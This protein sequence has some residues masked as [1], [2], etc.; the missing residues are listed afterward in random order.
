MRELDGQAKRI[1]ATKAN[2]EFL[3]EIA[4][5]I[6]RMQEFESE[7]DL[8]LSKFPGAEEVLHAVTAK[9]SEYVDRERRLV[10]NPQAAVARGQLDVEANQA[11]ITTSQFRNSAQSLIASL[12]TSVQAITR[13]TGSLSL[14]CQSTNPPDLTPE[15]IQA[16]KVRCDQFSSAQDPYRQKL[17]AIKR[18]L[19]HIEHVYAEESN[20]QANLLQAADR[21]R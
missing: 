17:E 14:R 5:T 7:V 3:A 4:Q 13:E 10:G 8:H 9:V 2:E 21:L 19:L 6:S 18:G 15:Q 20:A 12:E 11:S 16:R 1:L